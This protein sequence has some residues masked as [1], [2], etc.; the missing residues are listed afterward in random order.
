MRRRL[1]RLARLGLAA[2][3]NGLL[4]LAGPAGLVGLVALGMSA[5]DKPKDPPPAPTA[6]A[7]ATAPPPTAAPA[8]K[9]LDPAALGVFAPLPAKLERPDNLLTDEKVALGRQL[10]FDARLSK[11]QDVSCNSCHDVTRAGAD[12]AALSVGTKKQKGT[13][14]APSIFNAAGGFAQGW[15]ARASLVEEL[16]VPH[17]A[18][19]SVMAMDEK[20]LLAVITSI[21]AYAAAFQKVFLADKTAVSAENVSRAIGAYTRS[22]LT[23]ARWDAFLAGKTDALI[24]S[25]KAGV[26]LFIDA[27]CSSCHAGKYLGATQTQKLGVAKP[28]PE[29]EAGAAT[30]HGRIAVTKQDVDK[31]VFKVPSLRNVVRTAPYLHDGSVATLEEITKLMSRHQVGKELTDDQV[32]S[33][34]SF[35]GTLTGEPPKDLVT[36]PELP[37]SGPKTPKPE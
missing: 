1:A 28:W 2:P 10:Y 33:L 27:G 36:K 3:R 17:I 29:G 19:P 26:A 13:R 20:K 23:P 37:P 34:V 16:V 9:A 8:P 22:L 18:E 12:E 5:C 11:G 35:M 31:D 7:S 14:N 21:P 24:D 4:G 25:E 30:D 6:T 32:K 15:D